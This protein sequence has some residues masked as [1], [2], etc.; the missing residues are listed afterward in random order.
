M[1][2][3]EGRGRSRALRKPNVNG[4]SGILPLHRYFTKIYREEPRNLEKEESQRNELWKEEL[5][6]KPSHKA[7][8]YPG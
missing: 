1:E 7:W 5:A 8:R 2:E 6:T 3:K 4:K